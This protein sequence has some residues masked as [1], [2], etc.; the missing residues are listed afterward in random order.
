[1]HR[2]WQSVEICPLQVVK[3]EGDFPPLIRSGVL[4]AE[5]APSL[6]YLNCEAGKK[7]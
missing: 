7:V 1:M 5:F 2:V 4:V 6:P 3:M